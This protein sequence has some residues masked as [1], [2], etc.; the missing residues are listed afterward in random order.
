MHFERGRDYPRAVH[1][2]QQ[3]GVNAI[4]RS[5]YQ[6]AIRYLTKGLDL[7]LV[8]P[9]SHERTN[10]E[11]SLQLTLGLPLVATRGYAAGEVEQI[12]TRALVL[13]EQ[14]GET[15]LLFS[16]LVGLWAFH[17]VRGKLQNALSI[18]SQ[19]LRLAEQAPNPA[20]L[21]EAHLGLGMISCSWEI[22]VLHTPI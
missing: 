11:L 16:A 1:Y 13:C 18:A 8:L 19:G 15:P 2:L 17:L 9:E 21:L 5:A 7:L 6:E 20:F 10:Q 4:R 3:A 14:I 12:Y 22:S